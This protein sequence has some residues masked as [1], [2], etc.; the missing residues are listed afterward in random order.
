MLAQVE[1]VPIC[2]KFRANVVLKCRF[3]RHRMVNRNEVLMI[4]RF[5][6]A[7]QQYSRW[8]PFPE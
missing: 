4:N 2:D 1:S 6:T 5:D 3:N 8:G 7:P